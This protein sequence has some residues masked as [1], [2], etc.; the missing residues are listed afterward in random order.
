MQKSVFQSDLFSPPVQEEGKTANCL[1]I[2]KLEQDKTKL[3][4]EIDQNLFEVIS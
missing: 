1:L 3:Y 4:Q 2:E